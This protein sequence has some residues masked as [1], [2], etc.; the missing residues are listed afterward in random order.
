MN[1]QSVA[2]SLKM[3]IRKPMRWSGRALLAVSSAIAMMTTVSAPAS[4]ATA[5][6]DQ[7][8]F[9]NATVPGNLALALSVEF[10]TAVSR[11]HSAA[12]AAGTKFLGYFDADKCY[13]YDSA[14]QYFY[15][16]GAV[17]SVATRVCGS[18]ANGQFSGNYLNWA[19]MAV[20]DPFRQALTGGYRVVDT[21]TETM[22]E[23]AW[24]PSTSGQGSEGG[25]FTRKSINR[26]V[27][28]A[29]TPFNIGNSDN[30]YSRV[31]GFENKL[32]I[33]TTTSK[34]D[35]FSTTPDAQTDGINPVV[36]QM[37]E[38]RVRIKVCVSPATTATGPLE[39]NCVQYGVNGDATNPLH[40]K[41]EGLMQAYSSRIR[42]SAFGYLNDSNLQRDG[43]V[44]RAR[45]KFIGPTKVIPGQPD[46]S[47]ATAKEWDEGTGIFIANPDPADATATQTAYD[48][49]VTNSGVMNYLNKFGASS[50]IYKTYDPVSELYYAAIRY[51]KNLGNVA[52]W[53]PSRTSSSRVAWVDGFPVIPT[54]DDPIQYS[55]QKNY[56]L[57]IGDTNSHADKN[58]SG[59]GMSTASEPTRPSEVVADNSTNAVEA[60]TYVGNFQGL[61]NLGTTT[62]WTGGNNNNS[63]LM[64]GLAYHAHTVDIRADLTGKQTIATYWL[65]VLESGEK[66]N[67]QFY[68]ATKYGGFKVP[69]TYDYANTA[70]SFWLNNAQKPL[71]ATS[72]DTVGGQPRPD[73]YYPANRPD[74]MVA[75]LTQAFASIAADM[76]AFT[77]A[78]S[79]S[80]PQ[81]TTT[82]NANYSTQFDASNWTG[83][84]TASQ[85]AFDTDNVATQTQS[86]AFSTK[87]ATQ[88]A[89][90][91]WDTGRRMVTYNAGGVPFR[92]ADIS[93][94]QKT[95]LDTPYRAG[96]DSATY[97]NYLRG[98]QAEE[99]V[100]VEPYRPRAKLLGDIVDSKAT[101][102][103][104]PNMPLSDSTNPGYSTFRGLRSA[105]KTMVYVASNDGVVHGVDA[106]LTGTTAGQE[107][108]AYVP[109]DTFAG[110]NG[111]PSVDGLAS[112]GNGTNFVHKYLAN[113]TPMAF[114]IDFGRTFGNT[115]TDW[116]SVLIG[117]L[118]KG[119]KS[120][121]AI[122]VSE[123]DTFTNETVVASKV[124][125]EFRHAD[126]GYT[127]GDPVVV[128]MAKY[129]WVV[130][131]TS[132]YNNADGKGYFFV[133]NP[134][135]GALLQKIPTGAGSVANPAGMAHANSFVVDLTNGYADAAYAGD[136]LG[137]VWRL[138]LTYTGDDTWPAPVQFASLT[139]GTNAQPITTKVLIE[140]QPTSNTRFVF[141]GTGKLLDDT[142]ISSTQQQAFYA[143][144]DGTGAR[145]ATN[146]PSP[147]TYPVDRTRLAN[148]ANITTGV[149]YNPAT[150]VGWYV[151]LGN[152]TGNIAYRVVN[153]PTSFFGVIAFISQLPSGDA[154]A[155]GGTSRVYPLDFGTAKTKLINAD[156][157]ATFLAVPSVVTDARFVGLNGESKFF[158]G[159]GKGELKN[160]PIEPISAPG[161]TRLNWRELPVI[162]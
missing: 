127:Y 47:N 41:P 2:S 150:Q 101:V 43:A 20:I 111:T 87:L 7:P 17:P 137:N 129:G 146:P 63:A 36:G 159:T 4:A 83:E 149:T 37:Y 145:F 76:T 99:L 73:N 71:W 140:A 93:A 157:P 10:P 131:F 19:T 74:L 97:L 144:V 61:S 5:L 51:F 45:Q 29:A 72:T 15:P 39:A 59:T 77:T 141:V 11:A 13:R 78:L 128:K 136:L 89:G 148:V 24:G 125:W 115:G 31:L 122:D 155:P 14:N 113:A 120:Y 132:G 90:Q 114:D 160:P 158:V 85:L 8:L 110:P 1:D 57:G 30:L 26:T 81:L 153:S 65:D 138:D 27:A 3:T 60:T 162:N 62:P 104:K 161:L 42:Y 53:T 103:G 67:N 139:D 34:L 33:S 49:T 16:S 91:G 32:R 70:S 96:N 102:V 56:I 152:G 133:V 134:R 147:M 109:S 84:L 108:F 64:A 25:N 116:R 118:G 79:L 6:A 98:N 142:D 119:G 18:S 105:R 44:L 151:A 50:H 86:W 75:G 68:L 82:N 135:T 38:Y 22:L 12:Y 100:S 106:A 124:L 117:G 95:N 130:I 69:T 126:M 107:V 35:N 123:P 121:Y 112:R 55:C 46:A 48:V 94:T 23:K 143:I 156:G 28:A 40:Y 154:C 80:Q 9:S 92:Y 54:W 21:V 88:L 58:V 66:A 52:A